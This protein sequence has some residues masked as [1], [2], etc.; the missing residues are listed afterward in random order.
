MADFHSCP[1]RTR[2]ESCVTPTGTEIAHCGASS[3]LLGFG[4][5]VSQGVCRR[6]AAAGPPDM[7][8]PEFA[9]LVKGRLTAR[10]LA[11]EGSRYPR[12]EDPKTDATCGEAA[13]A[14]V[15]ANHARAAED[16][17][18][19]A[20]TLG[21]DPDRAKEIAKE[22]GLIGQGEAHESGGPD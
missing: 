3:S 15:K 6:C 14:L 10:L 17:I 1:G 11:P 20:V 8:N 2:R 12:I 5:S 4:H 16:A 18:V 9:R 7:D 22:A 13:G 19:R 21:L